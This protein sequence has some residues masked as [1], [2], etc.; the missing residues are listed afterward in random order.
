MHFWHNKLD[1]WNISIGRRGVVGR[2]PASNPAARVRFAAGSGILI[3]ILGLGA[4]SLSVYCP[5][6]SPA[7]AQTFC[8]PHIQR[9]PP[10]CIFL[11]FRYIEIAP[12][13]GIWPTGIWVVSPGGVSPRLGEGKYKKKKERKKRNISDKG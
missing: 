9:G 8:W 3:P 6:L 7:E 2:V 13:T 4:C 10:L 1:Y 11:V 12:P 5:V